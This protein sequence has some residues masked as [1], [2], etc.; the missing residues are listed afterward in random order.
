M[1][2]TFIILYD[3]DKV[4]DLLDHIN[5]TVLGGGVG[6]PRTSPQGWKREV[7]CFWKICREWNCRDC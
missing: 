4:K 1:G 6:H 2:K 7:S 5:Q 3:K